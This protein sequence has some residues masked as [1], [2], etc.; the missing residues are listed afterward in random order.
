MTA[1]VKILT[2]STIDSSPSIIIVSPNGHKTLINCGEGCQ[3]SFLES[4]DRVRSVNQVCI[5]H[6]GYTATGG[7]PGMILTSA[8]AAQASAT[9]LRVGQ[10]GASDNGRGDKEIVGTL[11]LIGPVGLKGFVHSLRFFMRRDRFPLTIHEGDY[12]SMPKPGDGLNSRHGKGKGGKKRKKVGEDV[13]EEDMSDDLG[14]FG[15][16]SIPMKKVVK[17]FYGE[18]E[19]CICSFLF[20]TTPIAG[21][22]QIQKARA[23]GI[24]PGPIFSQLKNGKSVTFTHPSSGEEVTVEPEQ[25]LEGGNDGVAVAVVYCPDEYVLNQ[26]CNSSTCAT[27]DVYKERNQCKTA[28]SKVKMELMVHYAPKDLFESDRYQ[29]WMREFGTLVKHMTLHPMEDNT[30]AGMTEELDGSPFRAAVLGAM[31]RSLIQ[32]DIYPNPIPVTKGVVDNMDHEGIATDLHV[33]HARPGVEYIIVPLSKQGLDPSTV[34]EDGS[35]CY[36]ITEEDRESVR[37]ETEK[38]RAANKAS[39]VLSSESTEEKLCTD[40]CEDKDAGCLI[41][42][43]TGSAIPCKHRN[44]TGIYLGMND[45]SG[46]LLDVGEGTLGQLIRSWRSTYKGDDECA[47]IRRSLLGI[48]AVWI[49]HPHADHHLGI[50]RLLTQRNS[51]LL[52]NGATASNH[53]RLILMSS[54]NVLRFL[55]EYSKVDPTI[56]GGYIPVDN[57]D[58]LPELPQNI[59]LADML[60]KKLGITRCLSV[61]V[62]HCYQSYAVVLDGTSFGRLVYS[63]DCRPSENLA[64]VGQGADVLIHE[65]TFENGMEE[66]ALLKSHSTVSEAVSV[67]KKMDAKACIL[68]HFSQRYPR[69]APLREEDSLLSFPLA[70]AFDFMKVTPSTI[71]IAAKLTPSLRLLYP[72]NGEAAEEEREFLS[73][74]KKIA[75]EILSTPGLFAGVKCE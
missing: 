1:S 41:F 15:I 63:G 7:L 65:A 61:P 40:E 49:S 5:T 47:H 58:T 57:R 14:L 46:M 18:E 36:G 29:A 45:G 42:T 10:K 12:H 21:K 31:Q 75:Q 23:L 59:E 28:E 32:S 50:I 9:A 26:F 34:K 67:A 20:T 35:R 6:I 55:D 37:L 13:N 44:V 24:P 8:D 11:K 19:T 73:E 16:T 52:E 66:E 68:T 70:F 39:D 25:V 62:S 17:T 71:G 64:R 53:E 69:I 22:F 51:I 48:K 4:T 3:R 33:Y 54:S 43:G 27:L 72:E 56:Y 38:C 74:T 60:K 2:T 30:F